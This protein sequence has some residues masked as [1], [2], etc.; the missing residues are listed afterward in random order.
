M[1]NDEE[2]T[3]E[4]D[5]TPPQE[6]HQNI[7]VWRVNPDEMMPLTDAFPEPFTGGKKPQYSDDANSTQNQ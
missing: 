7:G 2:T 1:E 3:A 5:G 4:K 6:T